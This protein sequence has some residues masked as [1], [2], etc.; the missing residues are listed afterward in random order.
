M[1]EPSDRRAR[2]IA[3]WEDVSAGA[4]AEPATPLREAVLDVLAAEV[5]S[6]PGL[7][8]KDRRWIT[9]TC[10][11]AA[12][13]PVPIRTHLRYAL[14]SGDMTVAELREFALHFAMYAGFPRASFIDAVIDELE[15]SDG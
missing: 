5:W 9:L 11:A 8:R 3:V 7:S 15:A 4:V 6:R 1:D 13:Q 14:A 2:A 10:V 12:G